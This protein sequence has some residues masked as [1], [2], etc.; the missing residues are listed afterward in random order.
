MEQPWPTCKH[1]IW[2]VILFLGWVGSMGDG[3]KVK[4]KVFVAQLCPTLCDP[5]V[6]SLSGPLSTGFPR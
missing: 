5:F 1:A 6:C 2:A 3:E 4:V